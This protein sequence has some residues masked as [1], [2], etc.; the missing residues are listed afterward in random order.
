MKMNFR[1]KL[2]DVFEDWK[3]YEM[4]NPGLP[5]P[6]QIDNYGEECVSFLERKMNLD[7]NNI[8]PI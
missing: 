6:D 5:T 1:Q 4:E 3:E 8:E 2:V 7:F